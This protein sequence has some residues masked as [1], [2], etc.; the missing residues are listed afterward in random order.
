VVPP[1]KPKGLGKPT[2]KGNEMSKQKFSVDVITSRTV[3]YI[4]TASDSEEAEEFVAYNSD[5]L[6][7]HSIDEGA[8]E[9]FTKAI[10]IN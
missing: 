4:V 3:T 1:P 8:E 10:K 7:P 9:F 5:D 6:Q 2:T